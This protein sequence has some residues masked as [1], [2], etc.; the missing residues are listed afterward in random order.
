MTHCMLRYA[1]RR[2]LLDVPD[3]R[4]S[5]IIPT[6]TGGGIAIVVTFLSYLLSLAVNSELLDSVALALGVCGAA[7][8][9]LGFADDHFRLSVSLRIVAQLSVVALMLYLLAPLPSIPVLDWQ[10]VNQKLLFVF[11]LF[12][13]VWL[14]NLYNFM[15]GIDG[16]AS[17][18]AI[19]VVLGAAL[20]IG[21]VNHSV[22]IRLL[23]A[24]ALSVA[25]FACLNWAPA[26]IFMGDV[27]SG[28][29]GLMLGALAI[30][31]TNSGM[32]SIWSWLILVAVFVS[33]ATVTLIR[34]LVSG[35]K[36]YQAHNSHAYQ[37]IARRW[38]SHDRTVMTALLINLF[39][40]MPLAYSA[41]ANKNMGVLI[42]LLAYGPLII[43]SIKIGAG[44]TSS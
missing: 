11:Y 33:D 38:R 1:H 29:L 3:H 26:K 36:I 16:L 12:A 4:S 40:L 20:I 10:L 2:K 41:T 34:R 5:H 17:V 32:I 21:G 30:V 35:E 7:I 44:R 27:G 42:A 37:I 24:L 8:A 18:E 13:L 9:M 19:S 23:L 14:L 43:L 6:A 25:G 22:E 39:W 28:F 31:T 15:D